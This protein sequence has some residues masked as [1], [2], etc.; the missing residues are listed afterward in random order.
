MTKTN[1]KEWKPI[2]YEGMMNK[3][4]SSGDHNR[5]LFAVIKRLLAREGCKLHMN[6]RDM[7]IALSIISNNLQD[8][9]IKHNFMFGDYS[10][11]YYPPEIINA[12]TFRHID[13][14]A[15]EEKLIERLLQ[16]IDECKIKQQYTRPSYIS[17]PMVE[18]SIH[19]D[20]ADKSSKNGKNV[21]GGGKN[22]KDILAKLSRDELD[23]LYNY[24]FLWSINIL[25]AQDVFKRTRD[26]IKACIDDKKFHCMLL[27]YTSEAQGVIR[28][29]DTSLGP[30]RHISGLIIDGAGKT[31]EIFDPDGIASDN[32]DIAFRFENI[33]GFVEEI[34]RFD[35]DISGGNG[36]TGSES[37]ASIKIEYSFLDK[38]AIPNAPI[39]DEK[40]Q[41]YTREPPILYA[42]LC[43]LYIFRYF[44][45]RVR[46]KSA[47]AVKQYYKEQFY[48]ESSDNKIYGKMIRTFYE[49][50]LD[51]ITFGQRSAFEI[52]YEIYLDGMPERRINSLF[53]KI[54]YSGEDEKAEL[55][56]PDMQY[57]HKLLMG[58]LWKLF[59]NE[60]IDSEM[61][62]LTGASQRSKA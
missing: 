16:Y 7:P 9:A 57:K 27:Q 51:N 22:I 53:V 43:E 59:D 49:I 21:K 55:W 15:N 36:D 60:L 47:K 31:I 52:L 25:D 4:L 58:H 45:D 20:G 35:S 5:I 37:L 19:G 18:S 34:L 33:K 62:S 26:V 61:M 40:S 11:G 6:G 17:P 1:Q 23:D 12:R 28:R 14:R 8:K 46:L 3:V 48:G 54:Y 29:G 32:D 2:F 56:H 39:I 50:I 13:N 10:T 24:Y 44:Y 38:F 41:Y 30:I 42:E